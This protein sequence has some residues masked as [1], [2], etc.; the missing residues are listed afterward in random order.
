MSIMG[1]DSIRIG[2]D[3]AVNEF[4]IISVIFDQVP[5][6]IDLGANHIEKQE[7]RPYNVSSNQNRIFFRNNLLIL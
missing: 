6:V 2:C 7:K 5:V 4:I 3:S 1:N